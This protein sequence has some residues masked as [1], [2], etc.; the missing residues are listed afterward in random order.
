M[1]S[2]SDRGDQSTRRGSSNTRRPPPSHSPSLGVSTFPLFR[3]LE[4][5]LFPLSDSQRSGSVSQSF[6]WTDWGEI[7]PPIPFFLN[8]FSPHKA[9]KHIP[10]LILLLEECKWL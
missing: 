4:Q 7:A 8:S 1:V 3:K 5:Q 10:V 9:A 6:G 2:P